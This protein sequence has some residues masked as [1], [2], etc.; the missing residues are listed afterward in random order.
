[1]RWSLSSPAAIRNLVSRAA[2]SGFNALFVQ[3]RGRGDAWYRTDLVPRAEALSDAPNDF[4]PLAVTA[5]ECRRRGLQLHA[6]VNTYLVWTGSAPPKSSLHVANAH[7]DW[8]AQ[9]RSGRN[10]MAAT[11]DT[12][13]LFLKPSHPDVKAHL[14]SVFLEL[15]AR[16]DLDGLHLDY[17]RHPNEEYD[18]SEDTLERF[19]AWML[20]QTTS[21]GIAAVE[22][23]PSRLRWVHV[24]PR[25]WEKWRQEQ[26]TD[27]VKTLSDRL[28]IIKPR[29]RLSAAVFADVE[30]ARKARGQNWA[31]WLKD[32]LVDAVC[33]MSY[34]KD[35][36][37]VEAQ[38]RDAVAAA[39]AG[40]VYAGIGSWRLPA[41]DTVRKIWAVRGTGA[42]GFVLFCYDHLTS[43]GARTQY[44]STV[45]RGALASRAA[46]PRM[47]TRARASVPPH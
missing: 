40:H 35:T 14:L 18:F 9:D 36:A 20:P 4:D 23:D 42:Q 28:N 8:L 19:A 7:P 38:I 10:T 33:P 32:G 29:L 15:A 39:G 6:W 13:G 1:M 26:I 44:L 5:A 47:R 43:N 41:G 2:E 30:D 46:A 24:F 37:K 45:Q 12:E 17:V 31:A 21:A 16:Y 27:F 22:K 34:A 11:Q 3:V 25:H